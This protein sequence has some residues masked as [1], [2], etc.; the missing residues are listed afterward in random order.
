MSQQETQRERELWAVL[1]RLH[2]KDLSFDRETAKDKAVISLGSRLTGWGLSTR[3][4][5]GFRENISIF[6]ITSKGQSSLGLRRDETLQQLADVHWDY[7]AK[8][9]DGA[10]RYDFDDLETHPDIDTCRLLRQAGCVTED[11]VDAQ[12]FR[13]V[14]TQRGKYQL[15]KHQKSSE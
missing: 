3:R 1:E 2:D 8:L 11:R 12:I 4:I 9:K 15:S 10:L 6:C 14:I 7:L 13:F 5:V